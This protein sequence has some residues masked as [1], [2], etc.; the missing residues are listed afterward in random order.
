M[1][2][3]YNEN[4]EPLC[5]GLLEFDTVWTAFALCTYNVMRI[6]VLQ[7]WNMLPLPPNSIRTNTQDVILDMP[8]GTV[9]LGITSNTKSLACEIL[10]SLTYCYG[11]TRRFVS[12]ASFLFIQDIAYG[13]LEQGSKEAM[14]AARHGWA[15]FGSVED[16]GDANLLKR[17]VPLGE[18]NARN[19]IL[20]TSSVVQGL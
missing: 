1:I 8:N 13:C 3:L 7:L 16:Y 2:T 12:T 17:L 15:K 18:M 20:G 9:L 5:P 14:W 19:L 6:F 11:K 10:R 4:G